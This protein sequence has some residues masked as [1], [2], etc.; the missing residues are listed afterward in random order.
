MTVNTGSFEYLFGTAVYKKRMQQLLS[1]EDLG[2]QIGLTSGQ[3]GK[4]VS[5]VENYQAIRLE[6]ALRIA[7][8]LGIDLM[9]LARKAYGEDGSLHPYAYKGGTAT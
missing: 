9:D 8:A 6:P 1:Q 2:K 5:R 4:Q 7:L 3:R